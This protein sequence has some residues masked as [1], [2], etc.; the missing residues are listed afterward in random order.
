MI[1]MNCQVNISGIEKKLSLMTEHDNEGRIFINKE[2]HTGNISRLRLNSNNHIDGI[3]FI[4]VYP[5][6]SSHAIVLQISNNGTNFDVFEPNGKKWVNNKE[7]KFYT[8]EVY[9]DKQ[10]QKLKTSLSPKKGGLNNIGVC[11][12]WGIIISILLN[13]ITKGIFTKEDKEKFYNFL[14]NDKQGAIEFIKN[15]KINFFNK[16]KNYESQQKVEEFLNYIIK[17]IK[18]II[19]KQEI[20]TR[21]TISEP[22]P[23]RKSRRLNPDPKQAAEVGGSRKSRRKSRSKSRRKSRSKSRS[24]SRVKK[25]SKTQKRR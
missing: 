23:Q 4:T 13:G 10:I 3:Y 25:R 15:I 14:N 6:S 11:G 18:E 24:K 20:N 5:G 16:T 19:Y 9:V 12:I 8:L 1:E 22:E 21:N 17:L 2:I 7:E